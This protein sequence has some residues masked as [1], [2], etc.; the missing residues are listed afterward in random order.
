[1]AAIRV[2][3]TCFVKRDGVQYSLKGSL[4]IQPLSVERTGVTGMDGI[5]GYSETPVVPF[6][7]LEV[8]KTP[9]LSVKAFEGVTDS[10]ITAELAD[11]TVY[12]LRNAW[13]SGQL[14]VDGGEG[15]VK[16]K[17]EGLACNEI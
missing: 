17:F 4:T 12:V 2:A 13:F 16:L 10:T 11:G 8:T 5:H 3:G 7:E 14:S 15:K 9:D 6:I 1:M